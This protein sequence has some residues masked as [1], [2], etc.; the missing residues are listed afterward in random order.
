MLS[1]WSLLRPLSHSSSLLSHEE[2][3]CQKRGVEL[4]EMNKTER[5]RKSL[6]SSDSLDTVLVNEL[7]ERSS[8][9]ISR[10]VSTFFL[11]LEITAW[12]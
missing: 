6:T 11:L 5:K 7:Q 8:L 1:Y 4:T 10:K 3:L 9:L 2:N 12:K